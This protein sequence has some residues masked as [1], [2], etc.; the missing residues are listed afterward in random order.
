[1]TMSFTEVP[2][3]VTVLAITY[4]ISVGRVIRVRSRLQPHLQFAFIQSINHL[5][6]S[7]PETEKARWTSDG[8][9]YLARG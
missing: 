7:V 5:D 6:A 9:T 2:T 8:C 3:F 1:M 4:E